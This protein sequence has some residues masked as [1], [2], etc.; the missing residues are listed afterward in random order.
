MFSDSLVRGLMAKFQEIR[1]NQGIKVIVITGYD[2]VF[3]MGGTKEQLIGISEKRGSFTDAPFLYR[4]LLEAEIPVITA[5]QGH[6]SGGGLLFGLYGDIVIMSEEGIYSAVFTKYGF[7]PGMGATFILKEKLGGN[8]ATEMMFTAK[9]F[10]GEELKSRGISMIFRPGN[11]VLI[12]AMEIAGMLAE[13]PAHTL[14][15]LKKELAARVLNQL[16]DTIKRE[17]QMHQQSFSHPEVKQRIQKYYLNTD[18]FKETSSTAEAA[19]KSVYKKHPPQKP[20]KILLKSKGEAYTTSGKLR[21]HPELK[22]AAN[23]LLLEKVLDD[24]EEGK[25]TPEQALQRTR[26]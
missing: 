14:R 3:C 21:N 25:I 24:L 5:I 8:L 6:A 13:K 19:P 10:R 17:E 7:T 4:G 15:I 2:K 22:T 1:R 20:P 9:S 23:T 11:E 18:N 16:D 12:E 26:S